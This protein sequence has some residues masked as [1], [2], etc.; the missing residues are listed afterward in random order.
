MTV[1]TEKDKI[2]VRLNSWINKHQDK[3]DQDTLKQRKVYQ[4][5]LRRL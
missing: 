4:H 1:E 3:T 2:R 5:V